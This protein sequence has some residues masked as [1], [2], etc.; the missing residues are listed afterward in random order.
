MTGILILACLPVSLFLL[1]LIVQMRIDAKSAHRGRQSRESA[2]AG[3][4]RSGPASARPVR[5]H[6]MGRSWQ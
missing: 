3:P 6:R 1:A 5:R 2:P 4:V